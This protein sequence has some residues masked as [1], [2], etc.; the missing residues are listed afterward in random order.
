MKHIIE[1]FIDAAREHGH[2]PAMSDETSTFTYGEMYEFALC[3]AANLQKKGVRRGSRVIV[4]IPRCKEYAGCLLGCWLMGAAAIPLSD[5]YPPERLDYIRKDS[6]YQL[7]IDDAFMSDMDTSLTT[8]PVVADWDDDGVIIY[9]SGST[10][11]PKGVELDFASMSAVA[12]RNTAHDQSTDTERNNVVGLVAPF[13]FVVGT[14]LLLASISLVKHMVIVPDEI[15]KDPYKLAKYYDDND[16][17]SSFV[18]P[19]MVDFMLKNNKSLKVIS[20]GSERITNLFFDN[21]PVVVNGYGATEL[22]G[23]TLAFQIDKSYENTPIGKPF[24][25]EKAYVL[26]EN[27]NEVEVGELCI[28][29]HVAKGYLNRPEET[30]KAFIR[31]PFEKVDGFPACSAR[32]ISCSGCPTEI[33]CSSSARTG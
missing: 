3:V 21:K 8:E 7:S 23:G 32:A 16:I 26:D 28:A 19:R 4:E 15:R 20:V 25:D 31:N 2:E 1:Q 18:P 14:G 6:Q 30:K 22:F 12:V 10:G 27:N 33:C 29:G 11:N 17:Q 9:T 13:T 5:D 24:G